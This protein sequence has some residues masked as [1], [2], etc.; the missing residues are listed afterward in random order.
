MGADMQ[1][2]K[3]DALGGEI[4]ELLTAGKDIHSVSLAL[5]QRYEVDFDN[6]LVDVTEFVLQLRDLGVVTVS[7]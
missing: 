2:L 7:G 4:W 1:F 6:A 5:T 3:L